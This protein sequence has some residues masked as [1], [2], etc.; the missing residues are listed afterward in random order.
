MPII[1]TE[2][3]ARAYEAFRD[4]TATFSVNIADSF[5]RL[6]RNLAETLRAIPARSEREQRE[7]DGFA[8]E[9]ERKA[10]SMLSG[11]PTA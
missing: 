8:D 3:E 2:A 7:I 11:E 10:G 4:L 5:Y 9:C 1:K 6:N